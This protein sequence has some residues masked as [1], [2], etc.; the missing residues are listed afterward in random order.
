MRKFSKK[1]YNPPL[2]SKRNPS[3]TT[4]NSLKAKAPAALIT[5]LFLLLAPTTLAEQVAPMP[6][7]E[8]QAQPAPT[9]PAAQIAPAALADQQPQPAPTAPTDQQAETAAPRIAQA[10]AAPT[11]GGGFATKDDIRRESEKNELRWAENDRRWGQNERRLTEIRAEIHALRA[12]NRAE[13]SALNNRIT[14]LSATL[15]AGV[16]GIFGVA[17]A[18][19]FPRKNAAP[20]ESTRTLPRPTSA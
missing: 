10:Q 1:R 2:P 5:A 13:F 4:M 20:T 3:P 16:L 14:I 15:L 18:A 6:L 11:T 9:A 17:L 7:A 19:I 12:E 8:R